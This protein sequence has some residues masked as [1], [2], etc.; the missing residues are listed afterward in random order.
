MLQ[1]TQARITASTFSMPHSRPLCTMR[2][3][4]FIL[5]KCIFYNVRCMTQV[6]IKGVRSWPYRTWFQEGL[7]QMPLQ[8]KRSVSKQNSTHSG[9]FTTFISR[10]KKLLAS[11]AGSLERWKT[12][13]SWFLTGSPTLAQIN[14]ILVYKSKKNDTVPFFSV[15]IVY[16][17]V[18]RQTDINGTAIKSAHALR[19][20]CD[21][22][23]L[24]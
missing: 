10:V 18:F 13:A 22:G 19:K 21:C 12:A 11:T 5:P 23:E 6:L 16:I 17:L 15:V 1:S 2:N 8:W 14:L 4:A 20:A 9:P 7:Y 3:R 24:L